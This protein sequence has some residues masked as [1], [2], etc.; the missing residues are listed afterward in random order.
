MRVFNNVGDIDANIDIQNLIGSQPELFF[1]YL[2]NTNRTVY[3]VPNSKRTAQV[4]LYEITYTKETGESTTSTLGTVTMNDIIDGKFGNYFPTQMLDQT[5]E[6]FVLLTNKYSY[7]G[8]IM[9]TKNSRDVFSFFALANCTV[10]IYTLDNV[11]IGS[12]VSCAANGMYIVSLNSYV[13][14]QTIQNYKIILDGGGSFGDVSYE[15]EVMISPYLEGLPYRRGTQVKEEGQLRF[16]LFVKHPWGGLDSLGTVNATSISGS[17]NRQ[18]VRIQDLAYRRGGSAN[19]FE[20]T[21]Q[22]QNKFSTTVLPVTSEGRFS[23][24]YESYITNV[25]ELWIAAMAASKSG[26]LVSNSPE[27]SSLIEVEI[28]SI[29]AGLEQVENEDKIWKVSVSCTQKVPFVA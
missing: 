6:K 28:D 29:S 20:T 14:G 7:G 8:K 18:S 10:G 17:T 1:D 23:Y 2:S 3:T 13:W 11:L 22:A 9:I 15:F 21:T 24:T 12:T 26:Y 19:D 25:N 5:T 27:F 16:N 4:I